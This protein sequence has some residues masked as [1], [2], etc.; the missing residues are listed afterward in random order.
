MQRLLLFVLCAIVAACGRASAASAVY[1]TRGVVRGFAPDRS[2]V[3]IQHESIPDFMP[4]MTMPFTP[5][6]RAEISELQIGDAI[7]F[8]LTVSQTD[9]WIDRVK[10]IP[11]QN[12]DI[13]EPRPSAPTLPGNS[14]RLSEGDV[15]PRFDLKNENNERISLDDYRGHPLILTFIFTRCP[16]PNFCPRMSSNFAAIQQAIHDNKINARLLSITLDPKFDTPEIL[17]QYAAHAGA[18]PGIW[19]FAT[20]EDKQ[21]D[22]LT[23]GF[24]IYR[25]SEGG[26]ISHGLATALIDGKG[27]INKVWRGNGWTPDQIIEE[28][29]RHGG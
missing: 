2:T 22:E 23:A 28:V 16:M 15:M 14:P 9:F 4:S 27:E 20:G 12:I 19:N 26:T 7:T 13:P 11:R 5:R 3:E 29:K 6:D 8:Q 18:D 24:S 21:I 10:K 25:Q 17:K 1:Q